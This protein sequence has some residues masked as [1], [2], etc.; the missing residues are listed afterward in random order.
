M[1]NIHLQI[2]LSDVGYSNYKRLVV[3]CTQKEREDRAFRRRMLI[4]SRKRFLEAQKNQLD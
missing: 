2:M 4:E 1:E 3:F